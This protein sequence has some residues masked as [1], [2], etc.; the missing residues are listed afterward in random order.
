MPNS[1]R[2]PARWGFSG[3]ALA[4]VVLG[5]GAAATTAS[6]AETT[7]AAVGKPDFNGDGYTD[8]VASTPQTSDGAGS[9]TVIPGGP[10]GPVASAKKTITQASPGVP[11]TPEAGD[12]FGAATA[13]G[14]VNGDGYADLVVG[15]PGED[16]TEG[17]T[18]SGLV[19]VLYGPTLDSGKA[20]AVPSAERSSGD[21]LGTDVAAA[22][23][24]A[25]GKAD[26]FTVAPRINASHW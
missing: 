11:G 20:I 12:E 4:L 13:W 17:R 18:D 10:D 22:D 15:A 25:D 14:D 19:T 26:V 2:T 21:R 16:D 7:A 24:N 8:L 9:L 6:A 23:F 3:A 5:G 1:I